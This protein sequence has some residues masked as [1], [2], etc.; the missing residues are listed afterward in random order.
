MTHDMSADQLERFGAAIDAIRRRTEAK[1][2]S[3]DVAHVARMDRFSQTMQ[4]VGRFLIHVSFEPVAFGVG[5][6]A[7]WIHKQLQ[8]TEIGHSAL[9][10]AYD[11]LPGAERYHSKDFAWEPTVAPSATTS[12]TK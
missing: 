2:G 7:L 11:K 12:S 8:A 10:G 6:I 4:I 1:I 3:E 5:V 9:H